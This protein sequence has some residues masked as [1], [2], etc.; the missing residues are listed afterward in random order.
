VVI[1]SA[2]PDRAYEG[3]LAKAG[4]QVQVVAARLHATAKRPAYVI[5]VA[6][7]VAALPPK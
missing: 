1:W 7:K 2:A 4:F 3:R 6:D 5:Y